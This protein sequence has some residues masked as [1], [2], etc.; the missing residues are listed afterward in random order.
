MNSELVIAE[1]PKTNVFPGMYRSKASGMVVLFIQD[2]AGTV[3]FPNQ[4]G[5]SVGVYRA[6]W[7][8]VSDPNVWEY[9]PKGSK[10]TITQE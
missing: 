5:Y 8:S 6:I 4:S 1:T 7:S 9:L 3:I 10:V 2:G